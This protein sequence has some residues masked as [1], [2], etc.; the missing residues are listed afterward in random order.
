MR[1]ASFCP[2][3]L[4]ASV[5]ALHVSIAAHA[6]VAGSLSVVGALTAS[7]GGPVADGAYELKAALYPTDTGGTAL[8]QESATTVSVKAGQ[9]ALVIGEKTPIPAKIGAAGALWFGVS[10]NGEPELPRRPLAS[11]ASALRSAV[12]ESLECSGCVGAS[13]LDPQALDAYA[14]KAQLHKV[15][16]SGAYADLVGAPDLSQYVQASA[17]AKVAGSGQ[18]ADLQGLPA[19]SDVAKT[20]QYA[21]L[22][23]T[24]KLAKV[25]TT[26]LWSDVQ[27]PPVLAK[28]GTACGTGL[29]V[30]GIAADGS[31]QCTAGY[32]PTKQLF[33]FTV[34]AADPKKCEATLLGAAY[35]GEKDQTLYVCNG[36]E[37]FPISIGGYGTKTNPAKSCKD[38]LTKVPGAKDGQYY[39][40][41]AGLPVHAYC[42]MTTD[43][44][45]WTLLTYAYRPQSGGSDVYYLPN[46]A[47]GTWDPAVRAGKAAI[48]GTAL[49]QTASQ[50]LLTVT[51]N[52]TKPV[53]GNAL[54]YELAYRWAKA[55]GYNQ[56]N[57]AL[58]S[59]SCI[60]V[61]VTE[62]KTGSQ[63]NA[64]TFDNRPQLSCSG[65]SG[66]TQYE[67]Q[68]IGFNSSTC[69]GA[70]GADPVTSNGMVVWYG[71]GYTPTTSGGL[72][73]PARAA[74]WG[75]WVR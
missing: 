25:A 45:G 64:Q 57:L 72:K 68:F 29:L 53:A 19:L 58:S 47:A 11:V 10:V 13:H 6:A 2:W 56:F 12:A 75:F 18:F 73:D 14:K 74:S 41:I 40:S 66:G 22:Q 42:D 44:G 20:G 24:P 3:I 5:V 63:F 34:A 21:D 70:C 35:V 28:V 27:N 36:S 51:N 48:D 60:T 54:S 38:V 32:D 43:G 7:A 26:G 8:W 55:S 71:D 52:G 15:A 46:A 31:L 62:L 67:R 37:W 39:I 4:A 61:S 59:T 33:Q 50:V 1:I 69:Y 49:L 16:G 17:L 65:H 23:G 9:F 30:S